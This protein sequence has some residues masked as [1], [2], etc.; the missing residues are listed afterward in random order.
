[1]A[2]LSSVRNS[3]QYMPANFV[4]IALITVL[5]TAPCLSLEWEIEVVDVGRSPSLGLDQ[6]GNPHIGYCSAGDL[7]YAHRAIE[8]W[9][10]ETVD[11]LGSVGSCALALDSA[12]NPHI[13]YYVDSYHLKYACRIGTSWTLEYVST[14]DPQP[15][16]WGVDNALFMDAADNPHISHLGEGLNRYTYGIWYHYKSSDSWL[17]TYFDLQLLAEGSSAANTSIVRDVNGITHL[18]C[19]VRTCSRDVGTV[20]YFQYAHDPFLEWNF[21]EPW[22][23]ASN[24]C[25]GLASPNDVYMGVTIFG[26]ENYPYWDSTYVALARRIG[27]DWS[28]E[29]VDGPAISES[30]PGWLDWFVSL[31]FDALNRPHMS[32]CNNEGELLYAYKDSG[33]WH[34][35]N[36]DYSLSGFEETSIA[37]DEYGNAHIAYYDTD[38]DEIKYARALINLVG[39]IQSNEIVLTWTPWPVVTEYWIYGTDVSPYFVPGIG[40]N[41]LYRLD[42]LSPDI[43][44][45]SSPNGIGNPNE[46]WTYLVIAVDDAESEITHSNR[47]G[48]QDFDTSFGQ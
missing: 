25:L 19:T 42:V 37:V 14:E 35:E 36:V 32:F 46:N 5:F 48:E 7:R 22:G 30:T 38:G 41:F 47:A 44:S 23:G 10:R 27:S 15:D 29:V 1:M 9:Y 26:E 16:W 39:G 13:S 12:G 45:W 6:S 20:F 18:G 33:G 43:T 34:V 28:Y 2:N 21:A 24:P 40:P 11:T 3:T 4:L 8:G 17:G 31:D